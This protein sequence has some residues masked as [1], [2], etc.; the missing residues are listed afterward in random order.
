MQVERDQW[1][2]DDS[3]ERGIERSY[4]RFK[5][6]LLCNRDRIGNNHYYH[7]ATTSTKG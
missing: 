5:R 6:N 3:D 7:A 1:Q 2:E 4:K